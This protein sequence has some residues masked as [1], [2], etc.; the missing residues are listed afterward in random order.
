MCV[1]WKGGDEVGRDAHDNDGGNPMQN[2]I[3]KNC[4][5]MHLVGGIGSGTV[6]VRDVSGHAFLRG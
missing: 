1:V 6:V 5:A 4:R 2:V 3:G